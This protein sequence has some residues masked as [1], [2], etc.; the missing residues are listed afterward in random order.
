MSLKYK[1]IYDAIWGEETQIT[2]DIVEY[3]RKNPRDLDL[4]LD[5]EHFYGRFIKLVL[6]LQIKLHK[7]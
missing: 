4:M 7:K 3:Y 2:D 1:V 6:L 5:K